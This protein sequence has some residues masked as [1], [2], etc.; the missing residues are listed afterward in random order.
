[1]SFYCLRAY[2]RIAA[3]NE[4]KNKAKKKKRKQNTFVIRNMVYIDKY[5]TTILSIPKQNHLKITQLTFATHNT[6]W[7]RILWKMVCVSSVSHW[8]SDWFGF[9]AT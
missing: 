9:Y 6:K 3:L 4:T 2:D 5:E 1:M 8:S 7:D